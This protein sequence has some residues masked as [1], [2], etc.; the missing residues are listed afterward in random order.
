MCGRRGFSTLPSKPLSKSRAMGSSRPTPTT[1]NVQSICSPTRCITLRKRPG[2]QRFAPPYSAPGQMPM[3]MGP[4]GTGGRGEGERNRGRAHFLGDAQVARGVVARAHFLLRLTDDLIEHPLAIVA[5]IA[6]AAADAR[7]P[8]LERAAGG[9]RKQH[10]DVEAAR[11]RHATLK[12][13]ASSGTPM[14]S[15]TS[16]TERQKS[17]S[18]SRVRTVTRASGRPCLIARTASELITASPSQLLERIRM[19]N[20]RS[21]MGSVPGGKY[22]PRFV[23]ASRKSGC[24][25]FQ[26]L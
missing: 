26:R 11:M 5:E 21:V 1:T 6:D 19:R 13:P 17:A 4:G 20:G 23:R 3:R 12:T 9:I 8:D 7:E 18:L 10:G 25:I 16:G 2:S 24:G 14:T 15:S 22:N